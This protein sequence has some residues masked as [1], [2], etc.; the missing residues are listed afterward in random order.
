VLFGAKRSERSVLKGAA[1]IIVISSNAAPQLR[2]RM[3]QVCRVSG[4][5]VLAFEGTGLQ[6]GSVCG[7]PFVVSVLCIEQAGKSKIMEALKKKNQ[8]KAA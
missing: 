3:L 6:L 1:K 7:K 4:V 5:P 8:G 2:E